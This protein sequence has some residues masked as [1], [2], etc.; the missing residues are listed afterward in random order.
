[1]ADNFCQAC[2]VENPNPSIGIFTDKHGNFTGLMPTCRSCGK[3]VG[4]RVDQAES[5]HPTGKDSQATV[6]TR[7][8]G[9]P[10]AARQLTLPAMPELP[11]L[12]AQLSAMTPGGLVKNAKARVKELT[13]FLKECKRLER[14]RDELKRLIQAAKGEKTKRVQHLS[15]VRPLAS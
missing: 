6:G 10:A 7:A 5:R 2:Q 12:P 11:A 3:P 8:A 13:K 15:R 1:M 14:E 9:H 4:P